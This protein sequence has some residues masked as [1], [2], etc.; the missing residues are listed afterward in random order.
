MQQDRFEKIKFT[1]TSRIPILKWDPG[2]SSRES[3]SGWRDTDH[4]AY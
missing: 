1:W 4:I 3:E 2:K